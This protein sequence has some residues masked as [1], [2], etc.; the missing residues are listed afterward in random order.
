MHEQKMHEEVWQQ[1]SLTSCFM[2]LGS[3]FKCNNPPNSTLYRPE[4]PTWLRLCLRSWSTQWRHYN[5]RNHYSEGKETWKVLLVHFLL[6][7]MLNT[8]IC[9]VGNVL[10]SDLTHWQSQT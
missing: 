7:E 10:E 3:T 6:H 1:D 4:G 2:A 8:D 9:A 5:S